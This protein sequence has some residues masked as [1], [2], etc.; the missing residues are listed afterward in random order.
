MVTLKEITAETLSSILKL[1]VAENQQNYVAN[2]AYS[3]AQAHFS[4]TAWFR[5]IYEDEIPVGF[6]MLDINPEKPEYYIWRLMIAE[7]HQK[8]GYG[9]AAVLLAI[10]YIIENT[11]ADNLLTS[12]VPGENSPHDFYIKLGFV[13]TGEVDGIE[14]ILKFTIER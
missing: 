8:K 5:G 6:I 14:N 3:I 9:K 11:T 7:N 10:N 12:T 13:D 4:E 1:K 2:N